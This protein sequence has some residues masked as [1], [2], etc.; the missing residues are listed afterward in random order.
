MS[1]GQT[2]ARHRANHTQVV[3]APGAVTADEAPAVEAAMF[4][5]M[6]LHAHRCGKVSPP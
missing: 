6:G 4:T 5:E 3:Y 1:R 2:V